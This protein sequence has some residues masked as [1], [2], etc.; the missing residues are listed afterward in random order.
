M[1]VVLGSSVQTLSTTQRVRRTNGGSLF[2]LAMHVQ[3]RRV[4]YMAHTPTPNRGLALGSASPLAAAPIGQAAPRSM[5]A[6]IG[7]RTVAA[8]AYGLPGRW[9]KVTVL[10][11]SNRGRNARGTASHRVTRAA[12]H[13]KG[14]NTGIRGATPHIRNNRYGTIYGKPSAT[15]V[16][17]GPQ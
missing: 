10:S 1:C 5:H 11:P 2:V 16:P 17:S 7:V 12:K 14:Q 6:V 9:A 3:R 4:Q 15:G 13:A 8:S